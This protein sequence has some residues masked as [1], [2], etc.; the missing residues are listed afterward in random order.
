MSFSENVKSELAET[1]LGKIC[2][3]RAELAGMICSAGDVG[4]DYLGISSENK[5]ITDRF[6]DIVKY[7]YKLRPTWIK[8]DEEIIGACIYGDDALKVLRD[9]KL[10]STPMRI[11]MTLLDNDCCFYS[12]LRGAF[13]GRGTVVS[14]EKSYHLEFIFK[15]F[16]LVADF[17]K[18]LERA[19]ITPKYTKR[20]G[21]YVFYIKGG[22][23][24]EML[25]GILGA[26]VSMMELL[27][28][29]IEKGINNKINRRMNCDMANSDKIANTAIE[30]KK[31]ILYIKE[32]IGLGELPEQLREIA[33]LRL[34]NV[35]MSLSTLAATL[36]I[37]KSGANHRMRRIMTLANELK[38]RE[39]GK[40]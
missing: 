11:N 25:L 13:L 24:V 1:E 5:M 16:S 37:S 3:A 34:E 38:E 6:C 15:R 10:S 4:A 28:V 31:A 2:C 26:H 27:N 29:K 39:K 30:Q 14:P 32:T 20:N 19:G 7:I 36:S 21:R 17:S 22:E 35:G 12:F 18:L 8:K 40:V 23:N 33:E 9:V